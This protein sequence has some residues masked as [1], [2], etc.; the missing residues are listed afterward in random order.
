VALAR[1]K[2]GNTAVRAKLDRRFFIGGVPVKYA[3]K[4]GTWYA[5][6][7]TAPQNVPTPRCSDCP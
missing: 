2:E 3:G 5:D 6:W 4:R 7:H 1:C